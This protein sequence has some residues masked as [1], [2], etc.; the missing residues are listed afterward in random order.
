MDIPLPKDACYKLH[1][2]EERDYGTRTAGAIYKV[3]RFKKGR[4][5]RLQNRKRLKKVL[6]ESAKIL[7]LSKLPGD[8]SITHWQVCGQY[9]EQHW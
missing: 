1:T 5:Q 8:T 2:Q 7:H 4:G 6:G 3:S 9:A